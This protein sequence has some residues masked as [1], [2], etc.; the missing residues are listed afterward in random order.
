MDKTLNRAIFW[1]VASRVLAFL[2]A[3]LAGLVF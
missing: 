1:S 3:A 2:A